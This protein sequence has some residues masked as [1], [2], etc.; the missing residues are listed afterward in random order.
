[1]NIYCNKKQGWGEG[2]GDDGGLTIPEHPSPQAPVYHTFSGVCVL[3]LDGL[4][5]FHSLSV[6]VF[7]FALRN[8]VRNNERMSSGKKPLFQ[9]STP[10]RGSHSRFLRP[11]P[12]DKPPFP[13]LSVG[14]HR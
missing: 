8:N 2:R 4:C 14:P 12:P 3:Y 10:F 9:R 11:H 5:I 7:L 1:M 6:R 13:P